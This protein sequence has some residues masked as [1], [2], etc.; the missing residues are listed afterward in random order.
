[1]ANCFFIKEVRPTGPN[2][3]VRR[4]AAIG[5][6]ISASCVADRLSEMGYSVTMQTH[7]DIWCILKRQPNISAVAQVAGNVH[8]N[9][10]A[11]YERDPLRRQKSFW[12]MFYEAAN[13]QLNP[14]GINLGSPVNCRPR[15]KV[16]EHE[17]E[18]VR[19]KF[20]P[21]PRPWVFIC[22]RSKSYNVR[23]VPNG[24][25]QEAAKRIQ[26]TCFWLG[27]DPAPAG[28]VDLQCRHLDNLVIWLSVADLM[29]TVDTGPM[30]IA[31][32]LGVPIVAMNQSSS[33][34][35][36]LNDQNDFV[37][38]S[39]GLDCLN[40]QDNLCRIN[41]DLPPCQKIPPELIAAWANARLNT[42]DVTAVITAYKPE[43]S[44][45]NRA[46]ECA[47]GQVQEVVVSSHGDSI[48]P[49]GL[50]QDAKVRYVRTPRH[51]LGFSENANFGARN[52]N[53]K[54]LLFLNDDVFLNP[55]A[56]EKL[57]E[58]MKP[59]V[60]LVSGMLFY[61]DGTIYH[62]GKRR[63]PG[64]RGWGHINF[65]QRHWE[66]R[67]PTEMENVNGAMIMV[68]RDAFYKCGCFDEELPL[69]ASDDAI[70]LSIRRDG[71]KVVFTPHATGIHLEHQST[72]KMPGGV[73]EYVKRANAVFDRKFGEYLT[74]NANRI[75]GD[76]GY[77]KR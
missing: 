76:F 11:S 72:G 34:S 39:P 46:I 40:C 28:I 69:Y 30:H 23:Q 7:Q 31:A 36:H 43:A 48:M 32:A 4:S 73:M 8:V 20:A 53:G 1:M 35:L 61:P 45:I 41:R 55:G 58:A 21:Y 17:K 22:P 75:P 14:R 57:R 15:I 59:G 68:R 65:R 9:L 10:D 19:Q 38:V 60:G 62:A 29:V 37:E 71:Y 54:Y 66:I 2:I 70:C 44:M 3:V 5:D 24:I 51:G 33:P 13:R 6:A 63:G 56:V 52:A 27:D 25:W 64:E 77:L 26:A 12:Q 18:A 47:M 67:E 49:P 42:N 74:W 16:Y 50:R